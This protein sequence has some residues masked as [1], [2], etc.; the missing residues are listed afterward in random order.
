MSNKRYVGMN[1]KKESSVDKQLQQLIW[2]S[3]VNVIKHFCMLFSNFCDKPFQS[4]L[5]LAGKA[6][7]YPSEASF[8]E[9]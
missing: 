6:R 9:Q 2:H 4:S 7:A 5:I 1:V 3:G 8:I